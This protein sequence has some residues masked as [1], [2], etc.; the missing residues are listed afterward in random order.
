MKAAIVTIIFLHIVTEALA[1][2]SSSTLDS[3]FNEASRRYEISP[4]LLKAIAMTESSLRT[5][6]INRNKNGS[7]DYGIMQINSCWRDELGYRWDYITDPCYNIMVGAWI[8]KRCMVRYGYTWDAIS[9]YHT[10]RKLSKLKGKKLRKTIRYLQRVWEN[11][12]EGE[13]SCSER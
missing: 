1:F 7:Y 4:G 11:I 10:G 13:K 12:P 9:C 5:D 3:C 8:L 2:A 6:A